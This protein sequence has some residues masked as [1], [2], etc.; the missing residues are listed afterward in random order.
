[1]RIGNWSHDL[2]SQGE[3]GALNDGLARLAALAVVVS[4]FFFFFFGGGVV[5][6]GSEDKNNDCRK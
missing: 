6:L 3:V 5:L 2:R 4:C 1:M